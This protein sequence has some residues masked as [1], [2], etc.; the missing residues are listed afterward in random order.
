MHLLLLSQAAAAPLLDEPFGLLKT[1][2]VYVSNGNMV[3]AAAALLVVVVAFLRKYGKK[4]HE[5]LPDDHPLDMVLAF[6]FDSKP[7]G[8]ALNV[9]TAVAGA[10]GTALIAGAPITWSLVAPVIAVSLS[11]AALWGLLKDLL[12]WLAPRVPAVKTFLGWILGQKSEVTD[13]KSAVGTLN[14]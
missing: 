1:V 4:V 6:L 9:L 12:E 10:L 13:L 2:F 11:G 5:A 14:K 3:G 7:G 8:W